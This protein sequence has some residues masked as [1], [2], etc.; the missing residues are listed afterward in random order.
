MAKGENTFVQVLQNAATTNVNGGVADLEGFAGPVLFEVNETFGGTCTL[1]PQGSFDGT[2][3]YTAGFQP[4]G[5]TASPARTITAV[6][7]TASMKQSYQLLDL[8]P[9]VRAVISAIAGGGVVTVKLYAV[10]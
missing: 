1:T 2:T 7:V 6:S 4:V 5:A 9:Q 10:S 3:W 8:Y